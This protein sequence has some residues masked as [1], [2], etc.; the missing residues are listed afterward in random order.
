MKPLI[1]PRQTFD[2]RVQF[3]IHCHGCSSPP[4]S[5]PLTNQLPAHL[6]ASQRPSV[7]H[8]WSPLP[9][10]GGRDQQGNLPTTSF[11]TKTGSHGEA[12]V[13]S[14][15]RADPEVAFWVALTFAHNGPSTQDVYKRR[16][17]RLI[18]FF[19]FEQTDRQIAKPK[20]CVSLSLISILI[21]LSHSK[22]GTFGNNPLKSCAKPSRSHH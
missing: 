8:R 9:A 21:C 18:L 10:H 5:P 20:P 15:V 1:A 13:P 7:A 4:G 2:S 17:I 14:S 16:V 3:Q 6:P 11:V 19:R 12:S 22:A